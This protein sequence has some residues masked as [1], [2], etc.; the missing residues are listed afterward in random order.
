MICMSSIFQ[1]FEVGPQNKSDSHHDSMM[2]PIP[3]TQADITQ[4]LS[5]HSSPD[6]DNSTYYLIDRN[7]NSISASINRENGVVSPIST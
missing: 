4:D 6:T 2:S 5:M 3:R 1:V 7:K